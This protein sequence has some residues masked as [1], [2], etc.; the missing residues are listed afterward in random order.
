MMLESTKQNLKFKKKPTTN[1][2]S[3]PCNPKLKPKYFTIK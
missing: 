2:N 3:T 1:C